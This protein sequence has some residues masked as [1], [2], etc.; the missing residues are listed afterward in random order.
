MR[1]P[2]YV[3]SSDLDALLASVAVH[4]LTFCHSAVKSQQQGCCS[5][6]CLPVYL[7]P[8]ILL[9]LNLVQKLIFCVTLLSISR[10][11]KFPALTADL[12]LLADPGPDA[13]ASYHQNP[14]CSQ[15]GSVH[16]LH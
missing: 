3:R 16:T 8:P 4:A 7:H 6:V 14:G 15:G 11:S 13:H 9:I 2:V 5:R 12:T 10:F 1:V